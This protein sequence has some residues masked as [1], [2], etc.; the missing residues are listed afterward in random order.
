MDPAHVP[1]LGQFRCGGSTKYEAEVD[2]LAADVHTGNHSFLHVRVAEDPASG[3]LIGFCATQPRQFPGDPDAAYVALI[4][5]NAP[6]RGGRD[7]NGSRFGDVLLDDALRTIERC[8]GGPPRP[9]I[10][11]LVAPDNTASHSLFERHGFALI[12]GTA[13]GYDIRYAAREMP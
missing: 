13:G 12:Q 5:V 7:H 2:T 9:P 4:G 1:T 11:A 6:F 3:V 10:W 8:W